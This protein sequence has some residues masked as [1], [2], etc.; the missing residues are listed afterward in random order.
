M[1]LLLVLTALTCAY[2]AY[3]KPTRDRGIADVRKRVTGVLFD[4]DAVAPLLI[5]VET[6]DGWNSYAT[7]S[8]WSFPKWP[9]HHYY[10]WLFG[11]VVKLPYEREVPIVSDTSAPTGLTRVGVRRGALGH[12]PSE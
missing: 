5:R 10:F 8:T 1:R 6:S 2:L 4:I 3:W 12:F 7:S 11:Y 9:R